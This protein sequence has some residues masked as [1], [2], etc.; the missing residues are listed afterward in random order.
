MSD[1]EY[2]SS[3]SSDSVDKR[4]DP[5]G[6]PLTRP[7]YGSVGESDLLRR[8]REFLPQLKASPG[9]LVIDPRLTKPD[10]EIVLLPRD[11]AMSD[12]SLGSH[13]SEASFGVEIDVGCGVFDVNGTVDEKLIGASGIPMIYSDT[14]GQTTDDQKPPGAL[15]QE[16]EPSA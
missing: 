15:I 4:L 12:C 1:A 14:I 11:R 10:T 5:F 16:I 13:S 3:S 7:V 6:R 2:D 8:V 9:A